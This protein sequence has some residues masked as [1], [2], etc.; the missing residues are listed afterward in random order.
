MNAE[1]LEKVAS[2]LEKVAL[3]VDAVDHE[4]ESGFQADRDKLAS[5]FKDRY[6]AVTGDVI[7]DDV[8]AK[9]ATAD[10]SILSAFERLTDARESSGDMGTPGDLSDSTAPH[11]VKEAADAAEEHFLDFIMD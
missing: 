10:V 8:F 2:V 6:E 1:Q 9:V 4:R 11:T 3:Y 5:I 7:D